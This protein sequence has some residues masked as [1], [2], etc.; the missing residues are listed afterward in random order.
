MQVVACFNPLSRD[1]NAQFYPN[2]EAILGK[3]LDSWETLQVGLPQNKFISFTNYCTIKSTLLE[4]Q[5]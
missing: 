3:I 2:S 4:S 1:C 5:C